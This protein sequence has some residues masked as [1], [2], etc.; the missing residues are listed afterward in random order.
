M[1]LGTVFKLSLYGLT[2]LVGAI[3]GAAEG[4]GISVG[5]MQNHLVLPFAS[6]PLVVFG[7]L[8]T[9]G[10][11]PGNSSTGRGLSSFWANLLGLIALIAT[12]HEFFSENKEGKLLAG[13]HLLLYVTWIVLFQQKTVRLYWFLMALGILQLA[14]AS[15]LTSKGWFG[16]C[17]IGYMFGAV[18]TLSIFSLWR[19]ERLFV[20]EAL[21]QQA[22]RKAALEKMR[23]SHLAI[24]LQSHV[25]CAVHHEGGT[26]WLSLRFVSGVLMTTCS[27]LLVSAVFFAFIP[28][29][30]VGPEVSVSDMS[31]TAGMV[32]HRT[33]MAFSVRLGYLGPVLESSDRVFDIQIFNLN[34]QRLMPVQAYAEMLGMAEPLFRGAVLIQYERGRWSPDDVP[35]PAGKVFKINDRTMT[36]VSVKQEISLEGSSSDVI[37]C[38]GIPQMVVDRRDQPFGEYDRSSGILTRGDELFDRDSLSYT[39][40]SRL[41]AQQ[42]M[43]FKMPV[44]PAV[45]EYYNVS[46]YLDKTRRLPKGLARLEAIAHR[47]VDAETERVN[48]AE[49]REVSRKLTPLETATILES[50]LRDSGEYTYSLDISVTDTSMDPIEDFLVNRKK[51]HCEYFATAL[52]LMLRSANIPSRIVSGYKGGQMHQSREVL[53]VQ[54]KY[55]HLWVEAWVDNDG[56]TTF[57]A[58][59]SDGRSQSIAAISAK[60]KS[61][62]AGMQTTFSGLWSENVLNMSLDRQEASLYR[63][64]RKALLSSA[65][66][67]RQLVT[68]PRMAVESTWGALSDRRLWFSFEGLLFT[69]VFLLSLGG[70]AVLFR[71]LFRLCR[72][73]LIKRGLLQASRPRIVDFYD[74][75]RK[76]AQAKG[77]KRAPDQ[78]QREFAEVVASAYSPELTACGLMDLPGRISQ[79][80]YRVRFGDESLTSSESTEMNELLTKLELALAN[81]SRRA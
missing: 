79:V 15:V 61:L 46:R 5:S 50:Y 64:L 72:A 48:R 35:V 13:T 74:R 9:E 18:W 60:Q 73:W 44:N 37:F 54:Q 21:S 7:F 57:D 29:V 67:L 77:L 66:F 36:N 34:T 70:L 10:H 42:Q 41:P 2:A 78:T 62:W 30:W 75:F 17:A 51:G 31:D 24:K 40:F 19:A 16:F 26:R 14:V 20:Q 80:F 52:A 65:D 38:L 71:R 32:R 49:Q 4:E 56:W 69:L 58:T 81:D 27:A 3:L 11:S 22:E 53:E 47:V 33:G 12:A 1:D 45:R 39:V 63:P 43:S 25:H 76:L 68:S 59:P 6:L 55:A 28:R 23:Q 8:L